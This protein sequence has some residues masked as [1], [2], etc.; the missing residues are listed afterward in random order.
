[1]TE[2]GLHVLVNGSHE[3][4]KTAA[5]LYDNMVVCPVETDREKLKAR[6]LNRV[7]ENMEEIEKRLESA[8]AFSV[9]YPGMAI[10]DNDSSLEHAVGQ[11]LSL[12][13]RQ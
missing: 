6:L 2:S 10:I 1:M 5:S 8:A 4:I 9:D 12:I 7:R 3:C 13:A 11:I